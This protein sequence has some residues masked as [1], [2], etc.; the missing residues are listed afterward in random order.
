V[1]PLFFGYLLGV[2]NV[3]D[4]GVVQQKVQSAKVAHGLVYQSTDFACF[5][6]VSWNRKRGITNFVSNLFNAIPSPAY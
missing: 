5:G 4:P 1:V 2:S 3:Q 6:N